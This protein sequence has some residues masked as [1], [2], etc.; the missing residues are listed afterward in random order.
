MSFHWT[1]N[2]TPT[3][4][5]LKPFLDPGNTG[6][7]VLNG[8]SNPCGAAAPVANFIGNPTTLNPGQSVTFTDQST[9]TPSAWAWSISPGTGWSFTSGTASS[10]NPVVTFNTVG[11]YT[12]TLTATNATGS[13]QEIKTNYITVTNATA[14]CTAASTNS[15]AQGNQNEYIAGVVLNTLNNSSSCSNYTSQTST[16]TLTKGSAYT[17][18]I[19]TAIVGS[20]NTAFVDDELAVWI[21]F[22][23]DLDFNDV[24]EQIGYS[25]ATQ[26]AFN[27]VYNFSVPANAVTGTVKMRVRIHYSGDT[28]GPIS[29]CGDGTYGE[30]EDYNISI[31]A[32]STAGLSETV[33]LDAVAVYPNP[34]NNTLNAD[35]STIEI[36]NLQVELLD[37]TGKVLATQTNVSGTIAQ[38]DM[39]Q[40]AKGMYHVRL[41]AGSV[42]ATR[43][44]VKL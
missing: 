10:Q 38:F 27:T 32:S 29:P 5:Q 42:T 12:I 30:V 13:D 33:I 11:Q 18:T 28:E 4:E 6:L 14:P 41:S 1:A 36:D 40:F 24:G 31:I 20:T 35:F 17:A 37:V 43:R 39:S 9:N 15:C 44:V 22:N 2:G 19:T 7:T 3:N 34:V 23:G 26:T 8:S 21:D 25:I 16:T